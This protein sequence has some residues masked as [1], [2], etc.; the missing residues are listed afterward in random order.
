MLLIEL[1]SPGARADRGPLSGTLD[2]ELFVNDRFHSLQN[3]Y[4]AG[5]KKFN[6]DKNLHVL[7]VNPA[8]TWRPGTHTRAVLELEGE[9]WVD[10]DKDDFDDDIEFRNAYLETALP[11]VPWISARVGREYIT[12][13]G[14]LVYEDSSPI[15]RLEADCEQGGGLPLHAQTLVTLVDDDSPYVYA[16]LRYRFSL[17]ESLMV[18]YGWYRDTNDGVAEIF[19]YREQARLYSSRARISWLGFSVRKFLG[20]VL[21]RATAVYEWGTVKLRRAGAGTTSSRMQG[22]LVDVNLDC[23]LSENLIATAFLFIAS[24]D[25]NPDSGTLR[26]FVGINPYVDKTNIFFNGG[27]EGQLTTDNAGMAGVQVS[28]TIAPGLA[29]DWRATSDLSL[30]VTGACLLPETGTGGQGSF[31]GWEVDTMAYYT[32]RDR[33]HFF[34]ELNVFTPG[35]YFRAVSSHREHV[36][37]EIIFGLNYFFDYCVL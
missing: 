27:I 24:G 4:D 18:S 22:Y 9:F 10:F 16:A 1:T 26:S 17:L 7:Y 8:L 2:F 33:L 20:P 29:L 12:T 21:L 3:F 31:Y 35:E 37:T 28:G 13:L 30:R 15:V 6:Q 25:R 5:L 32:F 34:L 14:G 36:S 19:N 11:R 23:V